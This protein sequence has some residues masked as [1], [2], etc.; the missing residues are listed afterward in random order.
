MPAAVFLKERFEFDEKIFQFGEG[1][2]VGAV[3]VE[4]QIGDVH[5]NV[6][7]GKFFTIGK[8]G[9]ERHGTGFLVGGFDAKS[10][11]QFAVRFEARGVLFERVKIEVLPEVGA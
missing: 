6:D 11:E 9:D 3:N 10:A 2:G 7:V 5:G 4:E 8:A 1:A